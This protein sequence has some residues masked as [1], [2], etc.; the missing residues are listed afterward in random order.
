MMGDIMSDCCDIL[1]ITTVACQIAS[2][3]GDDELGLLAADLVLLS[4]AL[5]ALAVR[6][7]LRDDD[8]DKCTSPSA[9]SHLL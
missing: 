2:C 6:R 8:S 3:L 9:C 5:A 4:D 7:D 1:L